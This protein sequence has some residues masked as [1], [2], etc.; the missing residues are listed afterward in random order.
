[1]NALE[2][3]IGQYQQ[4]DRNHTEDDAAE[5]FHLSLLEAQRQHQAIG[6]QRH[7]RD[8]D[9]QDTGGQMRRRVVVEQRR[10]GNAENGQNQVVT[11]VPIIEQPDPGPQADAEKHQRGEQ[12]LPGQQAQRVNA[13]RGGDQHQGEGRAPQQARAHD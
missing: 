2:A 3:M 1:M 7:G 4:Q 13:F 8:R 11:Q 6:E 12:D 9:R 10:Q 5:P